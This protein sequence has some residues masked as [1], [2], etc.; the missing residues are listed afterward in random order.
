MKSYIIVIVLIYDATGD[1]R[2]PISLSVQII[3]IIEH[4]NFDSFHVQF[5]AENYQIMVTS[6]KPNKNNV[7]G[8]ANLF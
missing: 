3:L 5:S 1:R 2:T 8:L 6:N 4:I 7:R